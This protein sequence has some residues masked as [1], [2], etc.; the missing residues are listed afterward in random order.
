MK[1]I[2]KN[3][4]LL[5]SGQL[6][7]E[8]GDK[9][10]YIAIT[11]WVYKVTN[12]PAIMGIVLFT[13][14]MSAVITGLFAG[15]I[16]D[17]VNRKYVLVITDIVRGIIISILAI[18]FY[19]HIFNLT[20]IIIVE[21]LVGINTA[22][23]DTTVP[24]A[25][26]QIVSG[27]ELLQANS[28]SQLI[29]GS[30]N[31]FGPMLAGIAIVAFGYGVAFI[32]NAASYLISALFEMF[33]SLS[34]TKQS[35]QV[36]ESIKQKLIAGYKYIFNSKQIMLLLIVVTIVHLFFGSILVALP[37]MAKELSHG[38]GAKLLG[39]FQS[40][41]GVGTI[42]VALCFSLLKTNKNESK[43]MFLGFTGIGLM[44]CII[45]GI[46]FVRSAFEIPLLML[47]FVLLSG[48]TTLTWIN[49][50]VILQKNVAS[51]MTGRVFGVVETICNSSIPIAML[52]FGFF[53]EYFQFYWVLIVSGLLLL[54][55]SFI[56]ARIYFSK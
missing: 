13:Q 50:R 6:V 22:F 47:A 33:I 46:G 1:R 21:I 17:S 54:L 12:S 3:L 42:I 55:S 11:F 20:L 8:F 49:F 24:A 15:S 51:A 37:V 18:L 39:C 30:S 56:L 35:N 4:T 7:S 38:E 28:K 36:Q 16:V 43:I 9:F 26:S 53:L 25:L 32:A 31:V 29:A 48:A 41:L 27:D 19:C 5:L 10:Y 23:F 52:I 44:F 14:M 34:T 2:N 45:A 40:A